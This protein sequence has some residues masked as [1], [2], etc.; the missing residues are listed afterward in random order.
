MVSREK[1]IN[2]NKQTHLDSSIF[3]FNL[4]K[5]HAGAG[6]SNI[7]DHLVEQWQHTT[8]FTGPKRLRREG[9]VFLA[10]SSFG[11]DLFVQH[12][13]ELKTVDLEDL[14]VVRCEVLTVASLAVL[15]VQ[16]IDGNDGTEMP[17]VGNLWHL[18]RTNSL[19]FRSV[20][21]HVAAFN[22]CDEQVQPHGWELCRLGWR[23]RSFAG[24]LIGV[25]KNPE[26]PVP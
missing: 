11:F 8:S 2:M 7:F 17:H 12:F 21:L 6:V 26:H 1:W 18:C 10:L 24:V 15:P 16:R 3:H 9:L 25:S 22:Y 13:E 20:L 5:R 14:T 4:S 19:C 23:R